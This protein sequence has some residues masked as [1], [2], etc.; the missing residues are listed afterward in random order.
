MEL[1]LLENLE[2]MDLSMN[3]LTGSIPSSFGNLTNLRGLGLEYNQLSGEIPPE[4][5]YLTNLVGLQLEY[6]QLSG[7]IPPEIGNLVNLGNFIVNS[8]PVMSGTLPLRLLVWS[9]W[10][11]F[12]MTQ[13]VYAHH[14]IQ[15]FKPG[16]Q[17][18][19]C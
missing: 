19:I 3:Q 4:I 12:G 1:G 14:P 10:K 8:N 5:G 2:Y 15:V 16:Y 17:E 18:S 6:N 7:N 11:P 13:L 9:T